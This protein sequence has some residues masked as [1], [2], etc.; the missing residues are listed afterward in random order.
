M[1]QSVKHNLP[2]LRGKQT[3]RGKSTR[4]RQGFIPWQKMVSLSILT[5]FS[6]PY[7]LHSESTTLWSRKSFK[8]FC[9]FS[10]CVINEIFV[11][12]IHELGPQTG[13]SL[14]LDFPLTTTIFRFWSCI[15][16]TM[17]VTLNK[18]NT[19][20]QKDVMSNYD[21]VAASKFCEWVHVSIDVHIP[22][23]WFSLG[24]H[25]FL[26]WYAT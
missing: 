9:R 16:G 12:L 18:P 17:T 26:L 24:L 14:T 5:H 11:A 3:G 15:I 7:W 1:D 2:R 4:N 10:R 21:S 6:I 25:S 8:I 23:P 22:L 20:D 19:V 13:S